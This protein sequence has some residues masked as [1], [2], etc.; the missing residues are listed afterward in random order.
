MATPYISVSISV[1]EGGKRKKERRRRR[2]REGRE[3][4]RQGEAGSEKAA[5]EEEEE[6]TDSGLSCSPPLPTYLCSLCLHASPMEWMD[7]LA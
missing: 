4:G 1:K 7:R 3:A 5:G 6:Q 2:S